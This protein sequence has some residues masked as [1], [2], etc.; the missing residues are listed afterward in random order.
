[1]SL[2][3]QIS[4]ES[5]SMTMTAVATKSFDRFRPAKKVPRGCVGWLD[6]ALGA[7]KSLTSALRTSSSLTQL[8]PCVG[9]RQHVEFWRDPG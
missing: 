1:M 9:L 7:E 5:A 4:P 3:V 2:S 8:C 6:I